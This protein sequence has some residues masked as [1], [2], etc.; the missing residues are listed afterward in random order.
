MIRREGFIPDPII[1]ARAYKL[2]AGFEGQF[3]KIK[4]PPVPINQIIECY[5]DLWFDWDDIEDSEDEK[6]LAYLE[7]SEKKIHLNARRR[8]HF[9]TFIGS[10]AF[11]QAHEVGHWDLHV[12]KSGETQLELPFFTTIQRCACRQDK[13]DSREIQAEKYAAYLLMPHLLLMTAI[14]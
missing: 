14:R 7:P 1:E 10:E 9:E 5:L 3:G 6:I 13:R 11:T 2:L 12:D 4:E 8:E